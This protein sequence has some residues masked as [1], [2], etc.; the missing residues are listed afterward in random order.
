MVTTDPMLQ[1]V[2]RAARGFLDTL[3]A[4]SSPSGDREGLE[5]MAAVVGA[6]L[7]RRG[8]GV[9]V[10]HE[11]DREGRSLPVLVARGPDAGERYL[12]LIGHLDTVLPAVPPRRAN[13]HLLGTG[14]LDMKGGFAALVGALDLLAARGVEAPSDIALVAVPDEEVGGAISERMVQRWGRGARAVLVLEPGELRGDRETLVLGRRGLME[15]RL[16]ARG[17][18]AHSGL[19]YWQGRSAIAAAARWTAAAQALSEPGRGPTVNVARLVGGD[20]EFVDGLDEHHDLV[21]TTSRLN[22]VADRALAEGELRF[23]TLADRDR[24]LA[25]LERLADEVAAVTEVSL[26]LRPGQRVPPVD[27]SGL[28]RALAERAV[29]AAAAAGW[30]LELEEDRGGVS[31][32]NFLPSPSELPILDG[33]GPVGG[34]MHTRGEFLDLRSL[35]RRIGLQADLLAGLG[36]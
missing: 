6:E 28:G 15:W 14:A 35:K 29:A 11:P 32:P 33:L 22:I 34:G 12:L 24:L 3:C 13:G 2:F 26:E 19:A 9:E 10:L 7:G 21:G 31:F 27:P 16:I 18:A 4:V 36:E 1:H 30:T 8:F 25:T 5:R 17:V 20:A 23:L